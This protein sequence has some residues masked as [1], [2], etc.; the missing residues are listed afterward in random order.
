MKLKHTP[1]RPFGSAVYGAILLGMPGPA[2]RTAGGRGAVPATWLVRLLGIRQIGQAALLLAAPRPPAIN[3]GAGVD[4]LH[5]ASMV[6][7]AYSMPAYRRV[8]LTSG[9]IAAASCAAAVLLAWSD[10]G[11]PEKQ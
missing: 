11:Q 10:I 9:G 2:A 8:T 1:G 3:V 7:V 4:A 5:A 6:A